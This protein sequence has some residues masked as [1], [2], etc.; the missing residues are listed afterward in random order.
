M[1]P[2]FNEGPYVRYN[3][4]SLYGGSF[5]HISL[6]LGGRISFVI[7]RTSLYSGSLNRGS[8]VQR[9]GKSFVIPRTSLYR[10]LLNRGSTVH[11]KNKTFH[12]F[13]AT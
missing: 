7:P 12:D 2:R 6:L 13:I 10:G 9:P 3:E 11:L 1:E 4:V 8:T 5:P